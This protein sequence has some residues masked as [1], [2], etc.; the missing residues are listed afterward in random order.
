L[1]KG[2]EEWVM[3]CRPKVG[4]QVIGG[5]FLGLWRRMGKPGN[6]EP[7]EKLEDKKPVEGN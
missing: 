1:N 3:A 5:G 7:A 6:K 2:D 4:H